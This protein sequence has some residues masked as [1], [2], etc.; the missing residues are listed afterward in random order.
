MVIEKLLQETYA[1]EPWKLLVCCYLLK[2][3]TR[4]QVSVVLE[5]GLFEAF[6]LPKR[7]AE[8]NPRELTARFVLQREQANVLVLLSRDWL[9]VTMRAQ[10]AERK[11]PP[12]E[13]VAQMCGVD[14]RA[15]DSYRIFVLGELVERIESEDPGLLAWAE[16]E[17]DRH[18]RW[19]GSCDGKEFLCDEASWL[20][21]LV[22]R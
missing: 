19:C 17:L 8:A 12:V 4:R 1:R 9:T 2:G 15:L 16:D 22:S 5:A 10:N 13:A 11:L 18:V 6:P 14:A 21:G 7:L 20:Y 3:L